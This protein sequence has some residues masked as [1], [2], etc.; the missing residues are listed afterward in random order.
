LHP[1]HVRNGE[2]GPINTLI[3][4]L[5]IFQITVRLPARVSEIAIAAA[6]LNGI[7]LRLPTGCHTIQKRVEI[8][9]KA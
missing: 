3:D 7:R 2:R 8:A 6:E 1:R 5:R 4:W 9:R